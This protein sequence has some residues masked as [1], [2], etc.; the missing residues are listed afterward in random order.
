[1]DLS[2]AAP[3][4]INEDQITLVMDISVIHNSYLVVIVYGIEDLAYPYNIQKILAKVV[5]QLFEKKCLLNTT[6]F[7]G[8]EQSSKLNLVLS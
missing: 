2:V 1:M 8:L 3:A 5:L 7:L 6:I 4:P